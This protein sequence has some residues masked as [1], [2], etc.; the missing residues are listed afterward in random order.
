ME[1]VADSAGFRCSLPSVRQALLATAHIAVQEWIDNGGIKNSTSSRDTIC[2]I[3]KRS[4]VYC[5]LIYC[6]WKILIARKIGTS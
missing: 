1:L 3:H 6:G 5:P 4:I 2:E